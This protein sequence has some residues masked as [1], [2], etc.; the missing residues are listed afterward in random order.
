MSLTYSTLKTQILGDAHRPGLG[1]SKAADFVRRAEGMIA[2]QLRAAEMIT[3]VDITD[4]DRVTADEGIYTLPTDFLEVRS[5]HLS[6]DNK[7]EPVSLAELRR[8]SGSAAVRHFSILSPTEIEFRG[9]PSDTQTME[10]IY[11]ARPAALS[12]S[13]D[14]NQ[15]LINH[16]AIYL[17]AGLAAL[18]E[19]TQD[20]ELMQDQLDALGLAVETLNEQAGRMIGGANT[21]GAYNLSS[22]GGY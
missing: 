16:E 5:I 14:S 9:V 1:D 8:V 15:I 3:R 7:L 22:Y 18:Y 11:F 10:L 21:F 12:A 17:H 2:R 20:R 4:S 13:D 6:D 19:Y